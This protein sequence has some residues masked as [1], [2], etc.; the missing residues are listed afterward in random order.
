MHHAHNEQ[1]MTWGDSSLKLEVSPFCVP[2][3]LHRLC[4]H[5]PIQ[6]TVRI[7]R[8]NSSQC[9]PL[10]AKDSNVKT[11]RKKYFFILLVW[12]CGVVS[13]V[14]EVTADILGEK[15]GVSNAISIKMGL[16]YLPDTS[17]MVMFCFCLLLFYKLEYLDRI[18]FYCVELS[19]SV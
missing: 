15:H 2:L 4:R 12:C 19:P 18:G 13:D 9:K 8:N 6:K 16:P 7:V 3:F 17:S 10:L 14:W 5:F 11:D 1:L